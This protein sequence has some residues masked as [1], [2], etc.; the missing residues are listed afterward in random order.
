LA[1]RDT[2]RAR[3]A[4]D[5]ADFTGGGAE[6]VVLVGRR[7]D[8]GEVEL[9]GAVDNDDMTVKLLKKLK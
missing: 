7:N 8:R 1:L 6:F 9:I 4:M 2:M 5:L 3:P